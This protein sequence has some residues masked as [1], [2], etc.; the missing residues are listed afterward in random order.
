MKHIHFETIDSTNNYIKSNY[1]SLDHFTWVTSDIQLMGKGRSSKSW[2]GDSNSLLCSVLL[3]EDISSDCIHLI[4]L[5]AAMSLH[6]VLIKHLP[7]LL[8]KWPNDLL[9]GHKK[10]SGILVESVSISN[11]I[12]AIIIGFGINLN[13]SI[14]PNQI[15]GHSTSMF[16]QTAVHYHQRDIL[17]LLNAQ[18][19]QDYHMFKKDHQKVVNYC[20]QYLAFKNQ[21]ISYIESS[22]THHGWIQEID[23]QGHLIVSKD[24]RLIALNSGEI[25]LLK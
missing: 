16:Q 17:E 10:V 20:N 14:F 25:T 22:E 19:V 7:N 24:N 8:I 6:Q 3:K 1:T 11:D 15:E 5:L 18:L 4:P 12:Q 13:H 21:K 23:D 9:I 2:Y